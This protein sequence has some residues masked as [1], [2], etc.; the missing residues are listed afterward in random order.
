MLNSEQDPLHFHLEFQERPSTLH[1]CHPRVVTEGT[2]DNVGCSGRG[3]GAPEWLCLHVCAASSHRP[4][5]RGREGCGVE[6][7]GPNLDG[8]C[9]R[10]SD[11]TERVAD[12]Q[13]IYM[14]SEV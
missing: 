1:R 6:S 2:N 4:L 7:K 5:A 11:P 8:H 9:E 12:A 14:A 13:G 10:P 3:L